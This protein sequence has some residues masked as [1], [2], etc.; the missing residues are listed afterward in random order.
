M[1]GGWCCGRDA[2]CGGAEWVAVRIKTTGA[3]SESGE[4]GAQIV[5]SY[6]AGQV[7]SCRSPAEPLADRFAGAGVVVIEGLGD[8]GEVVGLLADSEFGDR[9]HGAPTH[10]T[11]PAMRPRRL[12]TLGS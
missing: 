12:F 3:W 1:R 11:P 4:H 6:V 2:P 7:E 9:Q 10:P 8:P 5:G